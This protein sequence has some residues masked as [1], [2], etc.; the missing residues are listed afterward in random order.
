MTRFAQTYIPLLAEAVMVGFV[1]AV[2]LLWAGI[3]TG[4]L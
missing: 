4:S 3:L 1:I 2:A